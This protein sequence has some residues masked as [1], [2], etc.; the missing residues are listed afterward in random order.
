MLFIPGAGEN[1]NICSNAL[2]NQG[3]PNPCQKMG[4]SIAVDSRQIALMQ[5]QETGHFTLSVHVLLQLSFLK[6]RFEL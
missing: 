1:P 6:N 4:I 3:P 2:V 5:Y